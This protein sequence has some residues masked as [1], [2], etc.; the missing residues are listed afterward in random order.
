MKKVR[1]FYMLFAWL[2]VAACEDDETEFVAG[3]VYDVTEQELII[4]S[5]GGEGSADVFINSNTPWTLTGATEW[6]TFSPASGGEGS[7][8]VQFSLTENTGYDDRNVLLTLAVGDQKTLINVTQKQKDAVIAS[9]D[10]ISVG[11]QGEDI[12]ISVQSNIQYVVT[13]PEESATWIRQKEAVASKAMETTELVFTVDPNE[14][15][16]GRMG[17]VIVEDEAKFI[18][19]TVRVIQ[20][21]KDQLILLS[22]TRRVPLE[23]LK[24]DVD[25][26]TNVQYDVIVADDAKDWLHVVANDREDVVTLQADAWEVEEDERQGI[27]TI[28]DK[29]SDLSETFTV[30]QAP[31][32]LVRVTTD[33]IVNVP[34]NGGQATFSIETNVGYEVKMSERLD[35]IRLVDQPSAKAMENITLVFEVDAN[36]ADQLAR[37]AK[38]VISD[39]EGNAIG[40]TLYVNQD[41]R[42]RKTEKQ[43]LRDIYN[44]LGGGEWGAIYELSWSDEDHEGSIF[45]VTKNAEGNITAIR[46]GSSV[47]LKGELPA[48]IGDL[49]FLETLSLEDTELVGAI[50]PELG[51]LRNLKSL[52]LVGN[53]TEIPDELWQLE[54]LETMELQTASTDPLDFIGELT[55]LQSLEVSGAQTGEF[56]AEVGNLKQLT[57][58]TIGTTACLSQ[59]TSLPQEIGQLTNLKDLKIVGGLEGE[60]TS[61]IGGLSNLETLT[62]DTT[63]LTTLPAEIGN[64]SLL[65]ELTIE[66]STLAELPAE[67][68]NLQALKELSLVDNNLTVMPEELGNLSALTSM[69]LSNNK[70]AGEIPSS[71]GNLSALKTLALNNN[72]LTT[73][74]YEMGS[75]MA[76][77]QTLNISNNQLEGTI[78]SSVFTMP[79]IATL[80]LAN[81]KLTGYMPGT[82]S[83]TM[84]N[85]YLQNNKLSGELPTALFGSLSLTKLNLENN[86]LSGSIPENLYGG[87]SK[88]FTSYSA[89]CILNGNRLDGDI[90]EAILQELQDG[91]TTKWQ[92]VDQQEGYGFDNWNY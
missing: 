26:K 31:E 35:W 20:S 59:F 83:T 11:Q 34:Q 6:C 56:P 70:L 63:N 61:G 82:I 74:P 92:I 42:A 49:E 1:L 54:N 24:F 79:A 38:I 5:E 81:N 44:S 66:R 19:D 45:G 77:L 55:N 69:D 91:E 9:A 13:I 8:R 53:F 7:T 37:F 71:L 87:D 16:E 72:Q 62:I 41:G 52:I 85:L 10:K 89:Q 27:V 3:V 40:D 28:K 25:L 65:E 36:P 30:I 12:K 86:N 90:P 15:L 76:A 73:I 75:S 14:A 64:L 80:N 29:N 78:P 67:I 22:N 50:P 33:A 58:L 46:L 2:L 47:G 88:N 18:P 48:S 51:R 60:L 43:V 32:P 39:A 57:S 21:Q 68:G 4:G 17:Y 23:G 84:K